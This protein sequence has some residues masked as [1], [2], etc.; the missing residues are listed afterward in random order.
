MGPRSWPVVGAALVV[1]LLAGC[2]GEDDAPQPAP[3]AATTEPTCVT[4]G[5]DGVSMQV[6]VPPGF[7]AGSGDTLLD[8][9]RGRPP[10]DGQGL[11]DVVAID[12]YERDS[13]DAEV[14]QRSMAAVLPSGASDSG[15][16]AYDRAVQRVGREE[17]TE[18]TWT[19][20]DRVGD[21]EHTGFVTLATVDDVRFTLAVVAGDTFDTLKDE[22]LPTLEEGDCSG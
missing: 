17:L 9:V 20:P 10:A 13:S 1:C 21:G 12:A 18:I 11:A 6:T 2:Q 3:D 22:V 8:E 14:V 15:D 4:A 16:P 19:S 7:T 5:A